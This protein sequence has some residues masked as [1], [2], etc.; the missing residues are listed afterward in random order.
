MIKSVYVITNTNGLIG[1]YDLTFQYMYVVKFKGFNYFYV[2]NGCQPLCLK[3]HANLQR[4]RV[5]EP[6]HSIFIKL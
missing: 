3:V 5:K 2:I 1:G 4:M 6:E